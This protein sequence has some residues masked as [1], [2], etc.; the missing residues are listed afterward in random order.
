MEDKNKEI[1]QKDISVNGLAL[2][3]LQEVK[4]QTKRWMIAFFIVVF[5][6]AISIGGTIAGFIWYLNQY[7]FS[8]TVEQTGIYTLSDSQG[9]IISSDISPEQIKEILEI[10]NGNN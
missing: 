9:N 8:G 2:E 5:L 4:T 7:D 1:I 10:I 6:W 3:L